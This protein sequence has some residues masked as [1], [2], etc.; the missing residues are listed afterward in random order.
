[1]SLLLI[2]RGPSAGRRIP[3]LEFPIMI[4]R[5]ASNHVSINDDELSRFHLR[6]KKRGRLYIA[7]DL[8]SRNG[9]FINGDRI[10]NALVRNGDRIL[11]GSSELIFLTS[12]SN[13]HIVNEI[14]SF[15]MVIGDDHQAAN[16]VDI[17]TGH[18]DHSEYRP[19][20]IPNINL[21]NQVVK[22]TNKLILL[23]EI[24][25]NVLLANTI[26]DAA[27]II[28]KSMSRLLPNIS[29][30]AMFIWSQGNR[31]LLPVANRYFKKKKSNF[32]LS[33]RSI[34]DVL[35]RKQGVYLRSDQ[36]NDSDANTDRILL[37][38]IHQEDVICVFHIEI[39]HLASS[40]PLKNIDIIQSILATSAPAVEA[41]LL[42]REIDAWMIGMIETMIATI[43]AKDTYTYGHSERVSKY[44]IA[45]ADEL[46]LSRETKRLLLISALCHDIGKIGI[47]DVILKK[48]SML[49]SEE[50]QEMKLHPII[51]EQIL[52]HMPHAN[53][54]ISGIKYHH[55]KWDGTGYPD[56]LVGDEIP[57]FG[58]IIAV[59]DAFDAM[60]SGRS[61]SGFL[62]QSDAITRINEEK[63]LFD[64]EILKACTKAYEKGTLTQKT[65][66]AGNEI[67]H[68]E[69]KL[70][71]SG[72]DTTHQK[73]TKK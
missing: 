52:N 49:S 25:S 30:A 21:A 62:N 2:E 59:A 16:L 9:T 68:S 24:Q 71:A 19:V 8:E 55:E 51:G 18:N 28:L 39:D 5:D 40:N 15:R 27:Q 23:S 38:L 70:K 65:E 33:R 69:K 73:S 34:E 41:M 20:R 53:R 56:G 32:L 36:A 45:I 72:D 58:R 46:R 31:R 29:K 64:P 11:I 48:A 12:E 6:I 4:G 44:S 14:D 54:F 1:M 35:T 22:S 43:E 13:I 67:D 3:L 61:Y 63:E 10:L 7:E 50:Y 26:E 47:P 60:V 66:T 42:K 37:P 57:F 17:N